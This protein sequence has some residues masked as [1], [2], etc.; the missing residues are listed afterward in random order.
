VGYYSS[1]YSRSENKKLIKIQK[2]ISTGELKL[3]EVGETVS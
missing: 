3:A 1:V 2:W